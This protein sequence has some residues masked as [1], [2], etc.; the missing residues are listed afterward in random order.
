MKKKNYKASI[1]F[2]L[3]GALSVLGSVYLI[4]CGQKGDLYLPKDNP[5]AIVKS[6]TKVKKSS[7]K[8]PEPKLS[9][10]NKS[11]NKSNNKLNNKSDNTNKTV[12]KIIYE[13]NNVSG[14]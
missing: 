14:S 10:D 6:S 3:T 7:N 4:G 12:N 11:N 8:K 2:C 5:K 13:D 9:E 1:K